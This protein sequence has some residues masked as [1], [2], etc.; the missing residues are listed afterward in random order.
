[1]KTDMEHYLDS[2]EC[3]D[4]KHRLIV[5]QAAELAEVSHSDEAVAKC[6]FEVVR[7]AIKH[8]QVGCASRTIYEYRNG[9]KHYNGQSV[10]GINISSMLGFRKWARCVPFRT[11]SQGRTSEEIPTR[12]RHRSTIFMAFMPYSNWNA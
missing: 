9:L 2:G 12:R 6:C 11:E 10:S 7:N 8:S 5:A 3:I 1:M 4:W